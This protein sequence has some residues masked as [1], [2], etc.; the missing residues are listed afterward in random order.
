LA[1]LL[2]ARQLARRLP[3][4]QTANAVHPGVIWTPLMRHLPAVQRAALRLASP[5][6]LKTVE[7][8]A[9]TQVYVATRPNLLT[10][11]AYF[12]DC[13][14]ATPSRAASDDALGKRLWQVSEQIVAGL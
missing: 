3:E 5:L 7:Q 4:G 6:L 10:T 9:A 12:V 2:F 1:N 14:V 13:N 8:G 11:G